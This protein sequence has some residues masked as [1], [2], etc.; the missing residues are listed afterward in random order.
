MIRGA[1][2]LLVARSTGRVLVGLRSMSVGNPGTWSVFGGRR[3]EGERLRD[4]AVREL[5]EE[6]GL[7]VSPARLVELWRDRRYAVF[8]ATV[9]RELECELDDETDD[10]EWCDPDDLPEPLHPAFVAMLDDLDD[11]G[12]L[13]AVVSD[14]LS[15]R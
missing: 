13:A 2:V 3:E 15:S 4:T 9:P 12:G 11:E 6:A 7:D 10:Y 8:L 5:Y 14:H 1:G